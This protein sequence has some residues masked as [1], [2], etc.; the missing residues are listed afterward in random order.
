MALVELSE[1]K[2]GVSNFQLIIY[3]FDE[4]RDL[5]PKAKLVAFALI[6][7]RN[8]ATLACFPSYERLKEIT[9]YSKDTIVRAIRE[10]EDKQA[11]IVD[12]NHQGPRGRAVNHYLF[13]FDA[14]DAYNA[15][16]EGRMNTDLAPQEEGMLHL[17]F[18]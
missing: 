15:W 5:S 18:V 11:L 3:I 16:Q 2:V 10:L 12:R 13:L 14:A 8:I 6:R 1:I 4:R 7:H 9:G 17:L